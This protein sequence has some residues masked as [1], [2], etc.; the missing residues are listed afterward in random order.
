MYCRVL[1]VQ[2]GRLKVWPIDGHPAIDTPED[3]RAHVEKHVTGARYVA[4]LFGETM[5]LLAF[6]PGCDVCRQVINENVKAALLLGLGGYYV[7]RK[8]IELG[9]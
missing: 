8:W 7:G 2:G 3:I 5:T 4:H 1:F 6:D 9:Y